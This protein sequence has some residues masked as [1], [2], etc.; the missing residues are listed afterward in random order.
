MKKR[1]INL[2]DIPDNFIKIAKV[3]NNLLASVA[4]I[5]PIMSEFYF[6]HIASLHNQ[7]RPV[8]SSTAYLAEIYDDINQIMQ[9]VIPSTIFFN[10]ETVHALSS[11][12]NSRL[13]IA[14]MFD[15]SSY[16]NMIDH[17]ALSA[18]YELNTDILEITKSIKLTAVNCMNYPNLELHSTL[19]KVAASPVAQLNDYLASMELPTFQSMISQFPVSNITEEN[20]ETINYPITDIESIPNPESNN[21]Q[22]TEYDTYNRHNES[23]DENTIDD[24]KDGAEGNYQKQT[25]F[26][27]N[28]EWHKEQIVSRILYDCVVPG[29]ILYAYNQI[30]LPDLKEIIDYAIEVITQY[31]QS[32]N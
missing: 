8:V 20:Y 24:V 26:L 10:P 14:S 3:Q 15:I 11:I 19:V 17:S 1:Y 6:S 31:L 25:S 13:A 28:F 29:I 2:S 22:T 21:T 23:Y 32:F 5:S 7:L 4:S 12:G 30:G 16:T 27:K 9:P 18:F